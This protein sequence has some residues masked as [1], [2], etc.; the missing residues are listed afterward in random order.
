MTWGLRRKAW[1]AFGLSLSLWAVILAGLYAAYILVCAPGCGLFDPLAKPLH[2]GPQPDAEAAKNA[3]SYS[4]PR[5][6]LGWLGALCM[7]GAVALTVAAFTPFGRLIPK[8]AALGALVAAVGCWVL[9]RYFGALMWVAL[10]AGVAAAVA[11]VWPM[12]GTLHRWSLARLATR[13]DEKGHSDAA[14]AL[15]AAARGLTGESKRATRKRKVLLGVQP[16]PSTGV[17][18]EVT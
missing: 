12:I 14:G 2:F 17:V 7:V 15:I 4:D 13:L 1:T 9:Q 8:G 6:L 11:V 5:I 3:I 10:A 16:D 18:T